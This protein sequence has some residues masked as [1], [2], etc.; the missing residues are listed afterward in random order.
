MTDREDNELICEKLLGW[1]RAKAPGYWYSDI[2][3]NEFFCRSTPSF[4]D[5]GSAGLILDALATKWPASKV[6]FRNLGGSMILGSL[7]P[8]EICDAAVEYIRAAG[9]V[10]AEP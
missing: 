4:N 6:I 1:K 2:G 3:P 8:A 5:W 9:E 7:I 10:G